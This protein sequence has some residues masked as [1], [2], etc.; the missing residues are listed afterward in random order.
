MGGTPT[1]NNFND[2]KTK[3]FLFIQWT[4]QSDS[5]LNAACDHSC[6]A[7]QLMLRHGCFKFVRKNGKFWELNN[8]NIMRVYYVLTN[9]YVSN[10]TKQLFYK[11]LRMQNTLVEWVNQIIYR[12]RFGSA[13]WNEFWKPFSFPVFNRP[14]KPMFMYSLC[15]V[16]SAPNTVPVF[17]FSFFFFLLADIIGYREPIHL[18]KQK[19]G[20]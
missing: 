2:W 12:L 17:F 7:I 15:T 19:F 8:V 13:K 3:F 20:H 10:Y 4:T 1:E 5:R 6:K 11:Y 16:N 14:T 9:V 18:W